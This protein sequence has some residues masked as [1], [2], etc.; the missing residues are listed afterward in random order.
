M[1]FKINVLY[2]G[3]LAHKITLRAGSWGQTM[4]KQGES[5]LSISL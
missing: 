3:A 4:P 2:C 5:R 1:T